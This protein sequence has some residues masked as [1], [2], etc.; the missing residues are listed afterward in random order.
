MAEMRMVVAL[1]EASVKKDGPVVRR[2]F[3][4]AGIRLAAVLDAAFP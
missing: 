1:D 2:Q 3:Q 4:K